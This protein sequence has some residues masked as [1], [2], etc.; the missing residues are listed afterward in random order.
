MYTGWEIRRGSTT[1]HAGQLGGTKSQKKGRKQSKNPGCCVWDTKVRVREQ[2][3]SKGRI[4]RLRLY[5][6]IVTAAGEKNG[7]GGKCRPDRMC[8]NVTLKIKRGARPSFGQKGLLCVSVGTGGETHSM[9]WG[10]CYDWPSIT[11]VHRSNFSNQVPASQSPKSYTPYLLRCCLAYRV[12]RSAEEIPSRSAPSSLWPKPSVGRSTAFQLVR[13]SKWSMKSSAIHIALFMMETRRRADMRRNSWLSA[14][15]QTTWD[16]MP[17]RAEKMRVEIQTET[18]LL[19][20][21]VCVNY[22]TELP[23]S[24][25]SPKMRR[26]TSR[27]GAEQEMWAN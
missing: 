2:T 16:R 20:A 13:H 19:F 27:C 7:R 23:L 15:A 3:N 11:S 8:W 21:R 10:V 12:D 24:S 9:Q 6:S 17:L 25:N 1:R 4:I 26:C 22:S 14:A 18:V 5:Q